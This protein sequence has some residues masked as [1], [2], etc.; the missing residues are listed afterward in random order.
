MS[1]ERILIVDDLA[2]GRAYLSSLLRG[3]G[4]AVSE[5]V[6][7]ADAWLAIRDKLP[8]LIISDLLMPIMDGY[9]FLRTVRSDAETRLIPFIVYTATYTDPQDEKLALDL[10]AN[11]FLLKPMEPAPLLEKVQQ[12]LAEPPRHRASLANF[13]PNGLDAAKAYAHTIFSKL[14]QRS[15]ELAEA[16]AELECRRE[17]IERQNASLRQSEERYRSLFENEHTAM[18]IIDPADGAILEA[19]PAAVAFFG[20]EAGKPEGITLFRLAGA[21]PEEVRGHL[22]A[23]R[24]RRRAS[25]SFCYQSADRD[26]REV[27]V[28]SGPF[29]Q[30]VRDLVYSILHDV[31]ERKRLEREVL[32][33]QRLESI[34]TLA[35]GIAHDLNNILSPILMGGDVLVQEVQNP[36]RREIAKTIFENARR[37]A[38]L[39]NQILSFARGGDRQDEEVDL[40]NSLADIRKYLTGTLPPGITVS[41]EKQ[42]GDFPVRGDPIQIGQVLLNLC[43]NARDAMPEGGKLTLRLRRF[44]LSREDSPPAPSMPPGDYVAIEVEDTGEGI[45]PQVMDRIFDPFFTTK[46]LGR[47]T[48]LGLSTSLGIVQSHGGFM[49]V[50]SSP[51]EGA[52]FFLYFPA[53]APQVSLTP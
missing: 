17:Q 47:G 39:V 3:N 29:S 10:G 37:G 34:G 25:F 30:G 19:N 42:E 12:C 31:T 41:V 33:K 2:S 11:S 21:P 40:C 45:E 36:H 38:A 46:K 28:F 32:Q 43:I 9:T 1:G 22:S 23:A 35:G 14:E 27:E 52:R 7:G 13:D 5:A 51:G 18:L 53:S 24:K 8:D 50:A 48:G 15:R 26:M 20:L 4:F 6:N 49:G 44:S 16:V